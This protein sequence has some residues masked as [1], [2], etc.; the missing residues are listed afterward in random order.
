MATVANKPA[1]TVNTIRTILDE[2]DAS[3]GTFQEAVSL[4]PGCYVDQAWFDFEK[5]ALFYKEWICVGRSEQVPKVGDYYTLTVVDEPLIVVRS[6]ES[7]IRVMSAVC[8][9]RGMIVTAP[10]Q[11][12]IDDARHPVP[13]SSGNCDQFK[14]PYHYWTYGLD[15][16]LVGAP[17]MHRTS[18]FRKEAIQLPS[19]RVEIWNGFIFV[20]FDA[21]AAPL[22]PRLRRLDEVI[23][24]W[25]LETM[26][27]VEPNYLSDMPWNWKIMHENSIEGYHAD[28][29]HAGL[30]TILPSATIQPPWYEEGEAAIVIRHPAADKDYSLNPTFKPLLPVIDTLTDEDRWTSTFALIPPS[31]LMGLNADSAL[32]RVV[33]P[34][35]PQT[36]NIRYGNLIPRKHLRPRRYREVRKM[37]TEGM[38]IFARQDFPANAA[39]QKGLRSRFAPRGSYSWQEESLTAFNRWLA[40]RYKAAGRER[41]LSLA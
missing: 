31:L 15:G 12:E 20:N 23:E 38:R 40:S 1:E 39:V 13:D 29:L 27:D 18:S 36:I 33:L 24:N 11:S 10:G 14:C 28:R 4:P 9:H 25:H 21:E 41:G 26:V 22:A 37:V 17:E 30:H 6:T 34:T 19:F 5:D 8:R 7:E 2:L 3:V 16:H 32:Y 35:G